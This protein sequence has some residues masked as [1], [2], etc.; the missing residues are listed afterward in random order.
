MTYNGYLQCSPS[1]LKLFEITMTKMGIQLVI[2]KAFL[3]IFQLYYLWKKL[4]SMYDITYHLCV[5]TF[6]LKKQ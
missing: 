2:L 4:R 5:I 1:D 3:K 6:Q